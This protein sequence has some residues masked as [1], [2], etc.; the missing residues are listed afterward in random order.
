[1]IDRFFRVGG[2]ERVGNGCP[3][4]LSFSGRD[5]IK[6]R[7]NSYLLFLLQVSRAVDHGINSSIITIEGAIVRQGRRNVRSS[8]NVSDGVV[9]SRT[10]LIN[11]G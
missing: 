8:G 1:M 11:G 5:D 10:C 3:Y 2:V 9:D 7:L 4:E 6:I